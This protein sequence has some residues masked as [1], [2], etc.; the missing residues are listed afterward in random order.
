MLRLQ[1]QYTKH[2]QAFLR[3]ATSFLHIPA[4]GERDEVLKRVAAYFLFR[5]LFDRS[6]AL[7]R[8]LRQK[9]HYRFAVQNSGRQANNG[10]PFSLRR[11]NDRRNG[12][13][14]YKMERKSSVSIPASV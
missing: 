10:D 6:V 13:G 1:R 12:E 9:G 4:G 3:D 14:A 11:G 8:I 7:D 5:G 2:F